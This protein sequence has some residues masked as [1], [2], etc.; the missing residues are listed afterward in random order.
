MRVA[1]YYSY[2]SKKKHNSHTYIIEIKDVNNSDTFKEKYFVIV[3][4]NLS[5]CQVASVLISLGREF[6]LVVKHVKVD[7]E[8]N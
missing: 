1:K 4:S 8:S 7:K 2:Y 3:L 5:I 6:R